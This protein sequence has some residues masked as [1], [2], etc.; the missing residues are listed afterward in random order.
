MFLAL[1]ELKAARGRF[2]LMGS[3]VVLVAALVGIVSGFTTGLGDDTVSALRRLPA[4]H[5]AFAAG[6]DSDQFARGLIDRR[7]ADGWRREKGVEAT[8]LGVALTR[9]TTDRHVEVDLAAFGVVPGAFTDPGAEDG[10][11]LDTAEPYGVVV[12][13]QLASDGVRLGDTLTVDRIGIRLK[14]VGTTGRSS[15]GHVP[16][17]YVT[18]DTWRRIRFT[19]PGT[20]ARPGDLPLQYSAMALKLP[21]DFGGKR[22]TDADHRHRTATVPLQDAFAAA[23]GYQGERL[24]MTSIQTFLFLIAPLVVGAF[25]AVWTVQRTPELALLRAMGAS[26]R[27][28]LGH[29][30]AQAA[31]VVVAGTAVGAALASALGLFVG[32]RVPFSLPA[33]TLAATMA[34][35]ALVGLAGSAFTL[36]RVTTVDPM[37]ML[38]AAR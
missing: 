11:P 5:I 18:T 9:G 30:L 20:D 21:A 15:Y 29:T 1:L 2:L 16:A 26:R 24:T 37:T 22:L 23:P 34:A 38:G 14:V 6:T 4:T 17:A 19:T 7:S 13:R 8:P 25:F 36:R 31:A 10:K 33:T 35:V 27:R 32:E 28:L 3:V 12:S